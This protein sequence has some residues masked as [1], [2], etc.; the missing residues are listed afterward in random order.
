MVLASALLFTSD[1]WALRITE[2]MAINDATI[3][4][5][6]G[7]FSDWVEIYNDEAGVVDLGGYYL[8]DTPSV[9]TKWR[10]PSRSLSP[11]SYVLVWAS[12]KNR[13]LAASPLHANFKLSGSGE[14]LAI[15]RP[16]GVT[17]AH[18]YAPTF[19]AQRADISYGLALDFVTQRC[20]LTPTPG[21]ENDD[22]ISCIEIAPLEF[23]L[24]RGFYDAPIS[25]SI[26]TPTPGATIR[27]TTD[28]TTPSESVGDIY[29]GPVPI[30]T[31]TPLRVMAHGIGM[32]STAST[33]HSYIF[34]DD[35][36]RQRQ[37]DLV[38]RYPE[39]WSGGVSADYDMDPD[40]VDDPAYASTIIEDLKS[41]PTMSI[42]SDIDNLFGSQKGIY[43]HVGRRG[44][45]W[46]RP[47][48]MEV[49]YA[50]GRS[51]TQENAG[52]R[53]QGEFSRS[54]GVKKHS[55]RIS[56]RGIYG[57]RELNWPL[58]PD[59]PI[60]TVDQIILTGGH[61]N[62]WHAGWQSAQYIRDTFA[63]DTQLDMGRLAPHSTYVHVYLNGIYWG[64]YRATERPNAGFLANYLG[65]KKS[66]YDALNAGQAVDGDGL[67]WA[68]SQALA[69]AGLGSQ[70]AL[71]Q[72][73]QYVDLDSLIDF[74]IV[75]QYGNNTDWDFKNWY[76]GRR[77][78]PGAGFKFFSWDAEQTL[79][80]PFGSRISIS[81]HNAPSSIFSALRKD[82]PEFGLLFADHVHQHFFNDGALT[83]AEII[84][85]WMHRASEIDRAIVGE[86]ARWGD[87]ARAQPYTRDKEWLI[88]Q[89]RLVLQ[90]FTQRTRIAV[91]QYRKKDLYPAVVAPSFS[92]HGGDIDAGFA[93]TLT[94]PDGTIYYTLDGSDP[95]LVGGAVAPTALAY[96]GPVA[97]AST[98]V[99]KARVL[100]GSQWSALDQA[101]FMLRS[102]VRVTEI[103][104]NPAPAADLEFIELHNTGAST[105]DLSGYAFTDGITFTFPPLLLSPGG[106]TLLVRNRVSFDAH[107][108]VGLPIAGQYLGKLSGAGERIVLTDAAGNDIAD[109][110][111]NDQWDYRSDGLGYSL[112]VRD[113][114]QP[115]SLW[116][117]SRGW[118]ASTFVDGSP[119]SPELPQ[120]SDGIDNDADG[121]VDYPNDPGC[122]DSGRDDESPQ[123]DDGLDNDKDGFVD[124]AD[125]D[126]VAASSDT[127]RQ[128]ATNAFH[129]Y[130]IRENSSAA[131]FAGASVSLADILQPGGEFKVKR[132][133]SLCLAADLN[134][135]GIVD[136]NT[137][138]LAYDIRADSS[139]L[140]PIPLRQQRVEN[141]L[142]P[143]FINTSKPDRLLVPTAMDPSAPVAVPDDAAHAVDR[144]KCYR[145][146]VERRLPR[147]FP[148]RA[149]GRISDALELRDYRLKQPKRFCVPVDKNGA[150]IKNP[151]AY[152]L[153]YGTK[154]FKLDARHTPVVG[155][156]S[157][158]ELHTGLF[159]TRREEEVCVPS[160]LPR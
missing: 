109:F 90:Y 127:E 74:M 145:V 151:D 122:M 39:R 135:T 63:K 62:S 33:A 66:D 121:L 92:Q 130:S 77:R 1:A 94:A 146:S 37:A 20:F 18:E 112:V 36:I 134:R 22:S 106:I 157:A 119:G 6:D 93:L 46:E 155:I 26:S 51:G 113:A 47:I 21:S 98:V 68:T 58:F 61:G 104:Y 64:M 17:V 140:G 49:I 43:T 79:A 124:L 15:V 82:N 150:G 9:L 52:L 56:F 83:P 154:K 97:L 131:R 102:A 152:L 32:I 107:Y 3:V 55:F 53:M 35:V 11:G 88:E 10:F 59:A 137:H 28:G 54:T 100:A 148:S 81:N 50:N 159:D 117:D 45:A 96:S 156:H 75:N 23:S 85:R 118:R 111:Y 24:E 13:A 115:R 69:Q 144:Y 48:S 143:I 12:A 7:D 86:S 138:L 114:L 38:P 27:Y 65:G 101:R 91:E 142:S 60:D 29:A 128:A 19:V 14:Y 105:V 78:Q 123:C 139:T 132:P 120:C 126:C 5:E 42:V 40:V 30:T 158:N 149:V 80:S 99:V 108:G 4:D 71:D 67:A 70:T 76:A 2:F 57:A 72:L 16:D 44:M 133:K 153:C 89:R 160:I 110:T 136:A 84:R 41:I 141:M 87:K 34:L 25:V 116:D 73:R 125:L 95:R 103:M 129:C 31:T 8:T 147:Y